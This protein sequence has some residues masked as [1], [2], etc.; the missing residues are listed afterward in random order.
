MWVLL[1]LTLTFTPVPGAAEFTGWLRTRSPSGAVLLRPVTP[2]LRSSGLKWNEFRAIGT[3][4]NAQREDARG[5]RVAAACSISST[6][7]RSSSPSPLRPS[8]APSSCGITCP[9]KGPAQAVS[10]L[11]APK[12]ERRLSVTEQFNLDGRR[13]LILVRRDD[14]E[15]L[16]MTGGPVDMVIETGIGAPAGATEAAISGSATPHSSAAA[17]L[18][19]TVSSRSTL[20]P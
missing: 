15:H 16:I 17:V 8:R 19:H 2:T 3:P 11:F 7:L 10:G 6:I 1:T 18:P 20:R 9:G 12:P 5:A 14:V 4:R 13:R